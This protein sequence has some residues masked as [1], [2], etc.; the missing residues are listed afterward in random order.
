MIPPQ[1]ITAGVFEG[2]STTGTIE[3]FAAT[4]G[5]VHI[6][7]YTLHPKN[8]TVT[9]EASQHADKSLNGNQMRMKAGVREIVLTC[10]DCTSPA[11]VIF[12]KITWTDKASY[13]YATL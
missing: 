1:N 5:S 2:N 7:S 3:F 6:Y 11:V 12:D 8:Y 4:N 9:M 10:A 13:S